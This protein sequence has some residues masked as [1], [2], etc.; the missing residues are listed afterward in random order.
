MRKIAATLLGNLGYRV[1]RAENGPAAVAILDEANID[2]LFTDII[3]PGGMD[4][5]SLARYAVDRYPGIK[6]LY[7]SGYAKEAVLRGEEHDA[8]ISWISK[9][10][11]KQDLERTVR[12]ILESRREV[13]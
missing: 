7:A 11:D 3:M 8:E 9:P 13:P 2:L 10:Y 12:G 5:V 1:L 6:V 4:G